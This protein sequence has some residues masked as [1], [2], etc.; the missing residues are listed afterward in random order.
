MTATRDELAQTRAAYEQQLD[1]GK[2]DSRQR[3][4][5]LALERHER[6]LDSLLDRGTDLTH[7]DLTGPLK[8]ADFLSRQSPGDAGDFVPRNEK[9]MIISRQDRIT[10]AEL[11]TSYQTFKVV[12]GEYEVEF[13]HDHIARSL[14]D[15]YS[16]LE[17]KL[18]R[19]GYL[20]PEMWLLHIKAYEE[21][22]SRLQARFRQETGIA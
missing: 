18:V 19:R 2:K 3:T 15:K 16:D 9:G 21:N 7:P 10:L 5:I 17:S 13:N 14:R 1:Q 11:C 4:F 6:E 8:M 20:F 22:H 12:L